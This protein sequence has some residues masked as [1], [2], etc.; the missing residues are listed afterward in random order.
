MTGTEKYIE[1]SNYYVEYQNW[2]CECGLSKFSFHALRHTFATRCVE[3]G[4]DAKA[5]SAVLG[6][7][8]VRITLSRYVHPTMEHKRL[9]MERLSNVIGSQIFSQ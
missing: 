8:D 5:L 1:P 3:N 9:N 2:L 4:F 6:H 7:S